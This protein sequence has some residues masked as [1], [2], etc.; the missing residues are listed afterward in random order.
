MPA[1]TVTLYLQLLY[2]SLCLLPL[3]W[4]VGF[5]PPLDALIP[6]IMEQGLTRIMGGS[7]MA[8]DLRYA[9]IIQIHMLKNVCYYSVGWL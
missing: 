4:L 6:W 2:V 8:A 1:P 5:L 9:N 7:P 3:G